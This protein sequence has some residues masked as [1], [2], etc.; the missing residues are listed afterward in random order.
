MDDEM[1]G[2]QGQ[3]TI[4]CLV[5]RQLQTGDYVQHLNYEIKGAR[6]QHPSHPR[7]RTGSEKV[8]RVRRCTETSERN[9]RERNRNAQN[10]AR[11][12]NRTE[13]E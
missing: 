3:I 5:T 9:F 13:T 8:D 6:L 11:K 12:H 4:T 1:A 7:N 10:S 2:N